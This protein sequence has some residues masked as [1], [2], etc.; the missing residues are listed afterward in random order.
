MLRQEIDAVSRVFVVIDALDEC[1]EAI[2]DPFVAILMDLPSNA[3]LLVTSRSLPTIEQ[4]TVFTAKLEIRAI[5]ED[6]KKYVEA[7]LSQS[8]RMLR[9]LEGDQALRD[10]IVD[11]LVANAN[12]M[13]VE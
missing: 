6:V 1:E 8:G 3:Y 9:R 12:G 2:R 5:D 10:K 7:R 13:L 11:T 4:E